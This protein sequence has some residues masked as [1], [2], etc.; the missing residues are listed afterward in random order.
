MWLQPF[1]SFSS[2]SSCLDAGS[3]TTSP[4]TFSALISGLSD[5]ELQ[6]RTLFLDRLLHET[7]TWCLNQ[8]VPILVPINSWLH[9]PLP[10]QVRT[11]TL[12]WKNSARALL[13]PDS[14]HIIACSGSQFFLYHLASRRLKQSFQGQ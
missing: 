14:Q 2:S 1:S 5:Q 4:T 7:R 10:S 6:S 11:I 3:T 12:S 8:S 13:T 9:L